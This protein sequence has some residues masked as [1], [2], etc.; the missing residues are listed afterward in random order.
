MI[1]EQEVEFIKDTEKMKAL[2][3]SERD[4]K[5][6]QLRCGLIDGVEHI[7]KDIGQMVCSNHPCYKYLKNKPLGICSN[8]VRQILVKSLRKIRTATYVDGCPC[9]NDCCEHPKVNHSESYSECI[10]CFRTCHCNS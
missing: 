7:Y 3:L 6:C 9:T 2:G 8:R 1:T 5:V 4:I 10:V